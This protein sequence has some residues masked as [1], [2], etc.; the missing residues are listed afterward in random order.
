MSTRI[1]SGRHRHNM[2]RVRGRSVQQRPCCG[3]PDVCGGSVPK[4]HRTRALRRMRGRRGHEHAEWNWCHQLYSMRGWSVQCRLDSGMC[5]VSGRLGDRRAEQS[6]RD[7]MH[8]V[9]GWAIQPEPHH[10]M[11]TVSRGI[12]DKHTGISKR[13]GM[14][15]MWG[16]SLQS[17]IHGGVCGLCGG[18]VSRQRRA[19]KLLDM[20]CWLRHGYADGDR[21]C[22]LRGVCGRTVQRCGHVAVRIV[23][24]GLRDR[25]LERLRCCDLHGMHGGAV[26]CS[27]DVSVHGVRAWVGDGYVGKCRCEHV[28]GMCGGSIQ[29]GI[30]SG[31]RRVCRW[32][33]PGPCRPVAML[34][35][36]HGHGDRH[37]VGW[38]CGELH[39]VCGGS[40]QRAVDIG[41]CGV[42]AGFCDGCSVCQGCEQVHEMCGRAVQL[43]IDITVPTMSGWICHDNA[44]GRRSNELH[45]MPS[46]A[47]QQSVDNSMHGLQ[48]RGDR[49][50]CR[51]ASMRQLRPVSAKHLCIVSCGHVQASSGLGRKPD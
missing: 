11:R 12:R 49:W 28:H 29:C 7:E 42:H 47:V 34:G 27:V 44:D 45:G 26:Q 48:P 3:M 4:P 19:I 30:D 41:V 37:A 23:C 20:P 43:R 33:V 16:W 40:V 32:A 10:S 31:V 18:A 25:H 35:V 46:W 14:Y 22:E 2:H 24:V 21:C 17:W 9:C 36:W 8:G 5:V 38:W 6:S 13:D 50:R 1:D 39:G 15:Q 51:A